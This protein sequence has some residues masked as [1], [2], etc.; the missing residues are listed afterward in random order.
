MIFLG[1]AIVIGLYIL[2]KTFNL[3]LTFLTLRYIF[4]FSIVIFAI[5][6]QSEI[7]RY[8]ELLGLMGARQVKVGLLAPKSPSSAEIIQACVRLAQEKIG[9][10]VIIQGKDSI[11]NVIEGG[12]SLDGVI[13]EEVI[14]S[15]FDPH[16][17]GHDGALIINNNRI[18]KFAVH[19]PLSTNF[20]EIGKHGTRHSA[21]L[22]L[23]EVSD[24]LCIV[25]SEEKGVISLCKDGKL[26][27]LNEYTDL[28]KEITKY[29]KSKF[30]EPPVNIINHILKH[31]NLLKLAS[32]LCAVI[33]WFFTAYQIVIVEKT[34]NVPFD[35]SKVPENLV[36]EEY[37]PKD[38][39]V[40]VSA[41]GENAFSSIS[42]KDFK[43]NVDLDNLQNGVNKLAV[44]KNDIVVPAKF[45]IK[46]F[47]PNVV[48]LTVRKYSLADVVVKVV[49]TGN[50]GK[51][52]I[53]K[54][55]EATPLTL[56]VWIPEG[57]EPPAEILTEAVDISGLSKSTIIPTNLI[58]PEGMRLMN[59][60][61]DVSAVFT[62]E[63]EK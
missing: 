55:V 31:N 32:L 2:A 45:F 20:T 60:S 35:T 38:I 17:E 14:L 25:V 47:E 24:A 19:L 10:L 22:G 63:D 42:S 56:K 57:T 3:Y 44:S 30:S 37:T 52:L 21:A 59:G 16:S 33:L 28:E 54:S 12:I 62:I 46:S 39:K 61:V 40:K 58:L 29:I 4:G 41:R 23:S 18:S 7:R 9:A 51:Q 27:K 13:S 34:Y 8:M 1:V 53:L 49:T 15:I 43:I 50:L 36:I 11:D 5:I 26:K 48:L 6:F